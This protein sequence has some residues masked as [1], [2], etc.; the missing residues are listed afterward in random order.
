MKK[1]IISFGLFLITFTL[2]A[3]YDLSQRDEQYQFY[4]NEDSALYLRCSTQDAILEPLRDT[5]LSDGSVSH[6]Y[7]IAKGCYG[8]SGYRDNRWGYM[9][10]PDGVD[11]LLPMNDPN[12]SVEF[13]YPTGLKPGLYNFAEKF[14]KIV[15]INNDGT[16]VVECQNKDSLQAYY[17]ALY[18]TE[19]YTE[20]SRNSTVNPASCS[21][22]I[23]GKTIPLYGRVKIV[24]SSADIK[25]AESAYHTD[26]RVK[27]VLYPGSCGEW[28]FVESGSYD[29]TVEF[30]SANPD[31]IIQ[32]VS[33]AESGIVK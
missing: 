3:E 17:D 20:P 13:H 33:E 2:V 31:L 9:R 32:F 4:L 16:P 28:V 7:Y 1:L 24:T 8:C 5:T 15:R 23:R 21:I 14:A 25:V 10:F 26:L 27:E 22:I 6:I 30:N 12:C 19:P 29:F 18:P 11:M